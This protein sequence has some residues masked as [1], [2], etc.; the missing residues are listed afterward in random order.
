MSVEPKQIDVKWLINDTD[1]PTTRTLVF[2]GSASCESTFSEMV[3]LKI[4]DKISMDFKSWY[5]RV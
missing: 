3:G 1:I 2:Q 4:T 5:S